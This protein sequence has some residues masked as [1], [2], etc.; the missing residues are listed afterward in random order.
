M[1][2]SVWRAM[3]GSPVRFLVST[4]PWRSLAYVGSTVAVSLGAWVA[5]VPLLLFPPSLPLIGVP[6]GA[7]ERHRLRL[8]ASDPLRGPHRPISGGAL[9]WARRRVREAA[10]WREL[11]YAACL[12]SLLLVLDA[13]ALLA[14][15]VCAVLLALPLFVATVPDL[16]QIQLGTWSVH[17][18]PQAW[19]AAGLVGVPATL[20]TLYG[21]A[22]L[23]GA[24]AGLAR[25]LLAPSSTEMNRQ[26]DELLQSRTRLVNAF[27][28]ER[29]RIER[30]LHD[31]AQQH[32]VLLTMN[33]GLAEVELAG[34][35]GRAGTLVGE[36]QQQARMALAAIREQIR[37]IHPQV[38]TDFGLA[39]AVGELAE[40]CPIPVEVDVVLPGRLPPAV[41]STAYFVV[42]EALTNVVRHAAADHIRVSGVAAN[43]RLTLTVV[44]DGQ[45]GADPSLGT[46]LRGLADRVAVMD[47][48]LQ[49]SSPRG[50]PT[51]VRIDLPCRYE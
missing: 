21:L 10:T 29:R 19:A 23:A 15:F 12:L 45:G 3:A 37:G 38:L 20:L 8:L 35:S 46:G 22:V 2:A 27:E 7:L 36:A 6:I 51:T 42:S 9:T 33:L 14:L 43:E 30:D 31:G 13:G 41:E 32:L 48:T 1:A 17:T 18:V 24:Q 47:G 34:D 5:V 39:E 49:I 16:V 50:G 40:R 44:D 4:W 11:G 25:W 26:V 28:A